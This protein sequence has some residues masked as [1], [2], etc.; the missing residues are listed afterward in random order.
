MYGRDFYLELVADRIIPVDAD[1]AYPL[2]LQE[3]LYDT[4]WVQELASM[5]ESNWPHDYE[6]GT[7]Y[8]PNIGRLVDSVI[9]SEDPYARDWFDTYD[10][11]PQ[12]RAEIVERVARRICEKL[13][14]Y[15]GSRYQIRY[16]VMQN[17]RVGFR[18][19]P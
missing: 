10:F 2:E 13:K 17:G 14:P 1:P 9:D 5:L 6:A 4:F 15:L 16:K 18:L 11:T 8:G 7:W 19:E 12:D 3:G